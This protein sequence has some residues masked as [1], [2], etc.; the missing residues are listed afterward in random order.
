[1]VSGIIDTAMALMP[2]STLKSAIGVGAGTGWPSLTIIATWPDRAAVP[3]A[4]ASSGEEPADLQSGEIRERDREARAFVL[5]DDGG[6]D[7]THDVRAFLLSDPRAGLRPCRSFEAWGGAGGDFR[8]GS[9]RVGPSAAGRLRAR[10][11]LG[12]CFLPSR[13]DAPPR[14][15]VGVPFVHMSVRG[16]III[17]PT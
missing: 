15:R 6:I 16:L 3:R 4:I 8:P 10:P 17:A 5:C 1:M 9:R 12:P 14:M 13:A 2:G 7:S 11:S